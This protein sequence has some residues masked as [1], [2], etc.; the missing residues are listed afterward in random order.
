MLFADSMIRLPDHSVM[1]LDRT[2]MAH[3]LEARSPFM[4][5]KLAEFVATLAPS[6]K[7]RGRTRRYIQ[8]RVGERYL[9]PEIM[10]RKK[11]GFSSALPYMLA[12]QYRRLYQA[13]LYDSHLV[14]DGYLSQEKIT[15]LVEL[16]LGKKVD[17]SN[18]LWL[19]CN[20]EIWYRMGIEEWTKEEVRERLVGDK[21][22]KMGWPVG[23]MP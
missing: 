19:L 7:V 23:A 5:H 20:A 14:R 4:D 6:L 21:P 2:T 15:N 17:H 13:F 10:H 3:G 11:I 9:P 12:D 22:N 18:R 1:I 16:H 8:S